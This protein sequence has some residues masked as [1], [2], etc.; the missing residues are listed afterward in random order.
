MHKLQNGS[1]VQ[2]RPPRKPLVGLG[3][4][5][6]ES[7][8]QGAPSYPGQDW[9]ND[10]TDEFLNALA[11]AGIEYDHGR[12][13]HLARMISGSNFAWLSMPIGS[14]F[15]YD[16][17]LADLPPSDSSAFRYLV[18]TRNHPYN[19]NIL[20]NETITGVAPTVSIT[21]EIDYPLSPL[22]GKRIE[23]INSSSLFLRP[24]ESV[25][26]LN[27]DLIRNF[28]FNISASNNTQVGGAAVGV[29]DFQSGGVQVPDGGLV[30]GLISVSLNLS[31]QVP[32]GNQ[33]QPV[34]KQFPIFMRIL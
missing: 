2:V 4:Y 1:Q 10:C 11:A 3:G 8:E 15:F 5:F 33:N 30:T 14:P 18:L 32:V 25:S 24:G 28:T 29:L 26:G 19:E 6:S 23:L 27:T 22:H 17:D 16:T 7:N 21:A 20:I 12:L 13:D 34:N 9:F 31:K